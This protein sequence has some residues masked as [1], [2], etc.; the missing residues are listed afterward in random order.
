ME[1]RE[2]DRIACE[3]KIK[4]RTSYGGG[5]E[6][7]RWQ[8]GWE[9]EKKGDRAEQ[10]LMI[11]MYEHATVKCITLYANLNFLYHEIEKINKI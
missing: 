4:G 2:G 5:N 11:H 10:C 9:R 7:A 1:W 3:K 8:R 6:P